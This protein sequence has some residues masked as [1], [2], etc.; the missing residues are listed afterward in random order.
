MQADPVS[1]LLEVELTF[2]NGAAGAGAVPGTLVTARVEVGR[3]EAAVLVPRS[4]VSEGTAW[5]IDTAG[6]AHRR[7]VTT[8][9]EGDGRVEI[10]AGLTPGE[11]VVVAGATLLSEGAQT[12]VVGES[13]S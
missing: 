11:R 9:L 12:R 5:V 1:R 3:R 6:V 10:R 4:A 2:P 8:G 7:A 13:A